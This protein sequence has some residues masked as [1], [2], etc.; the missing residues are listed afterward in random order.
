MQQLNL[1]VEALHLRVDCR[2]GGSSRLHGTRSPCAQSTSLRKNW[3][4]SRDLLPSD[5]PHDDLQHLR[6]RP[7]RQVPVERSLGKLFAEENLQQPLSPLLSSP[8]HSIKRSSIRNAKTQ[9]EHSDRLASPRTALLAESISPRKVTSVG[10]NIVQRLGS[11][12]VKVLSC[13]SCPRS[14]QE[15]G[16]VSP[17]HAFSSLL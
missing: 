2:L 4:Q 7:R 12:A 8:T 17:H 3:P 5:S 1:S 15:D 9:R 16:Y 10:V 11:V 6:L 14:V 13:S